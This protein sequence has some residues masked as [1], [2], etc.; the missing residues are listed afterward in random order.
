MAVGVVAVVGLVVVL[1]MNRKKLPCCKGKNDPAKVVPAESET[2]KKGKKKK[3][4]GMKSR[5]SSVVMAK[6][7]A[8]KHAKAA[9]EMWGEVGA[10]KVKILTT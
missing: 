4:N 1:V 9:Q 3:K 5:R 8:K 7:A 2:S 10:E 6:E